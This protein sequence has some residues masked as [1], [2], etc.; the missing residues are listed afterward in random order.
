[1]FKPNMYLKFLNSIIYYDI[2]TYYDSISM[3]IIPIHNFNFLFYRLPEKNLIIRY[4]YEY[5]S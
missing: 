3:A 4:I 5:I 1:M 2:G